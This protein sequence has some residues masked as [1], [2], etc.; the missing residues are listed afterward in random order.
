MRRER[1]RA[2]VPA[3]FSVTWLVGDFLHHAAGLGRLCVLGD[4]CLRD[5]A[6]EPPVSLDDW[7]P[8]NLM[9]G[10]QLQ[11]VVEPLSW[12]D[13]DDVA[14]GDFT[15]C[16]RLRVPALGYHAR[17]DISIGQGADEPASGA[18]N[19]CVYPVTLV[20]GRHVVGVLLTLFGVGRGRVRDLVVAVVFARRRSILI[21][22]ARHSS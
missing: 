4:V 19:G 2:L 10:H 13:G 9:L 8:P 1:W 17:S 18:A 22:H 7:E 6:D 20:R 11:G 14:R 3:T 16:G 21:V 15:H 5:H 12:V